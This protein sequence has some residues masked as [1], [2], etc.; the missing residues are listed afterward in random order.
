MTSSNRL[1]FGLVAAIS[2]LTVLIGTYAW[3]HLDC[4]PIG[5]ADCVPLQWDQAL[6]ASVLAIGGSDIYHNHP[7]AG[8]QF[9]RWLGAASGLA[10]VL[11]VVFVFAA[12][13]LRRRRVARLSGH[14]VLVGVND[15]S[16]SYLLARKARGDTLVLIDTE[17]VLSAQTLKDRSGD[18]LKAEIDFIDDAALDAA[19]GRSPAEVVFG[20]PEA[21]VN[22]E[23][24]Q[25]LVRLR[26]KFPMRIRSEKQNINADLDLWSHTF[27]AVPILSET[28]FT[29]RALVTELEPM[30]IA[31]LRGQDCPHIAIIGIGDMALGIIEELGLRCHARDL[32]KLK[33][34]T[35]DCDAEAAW[36]KLKMERGGL[37]DA[38]D[39][40]R[41]EQLD[42]AQCGS[43]GVAKDPLIAAEARVA[44]LTAIIVC[45]GSDAINVDI[46][47]RLRRLQDEQGLCLAPILMRSRATSTVAPDP[48]TDV[49]CGLYRFGGPQVRVTDL[50]FDKMQMRLGRAMH[51]IWNTAE[52]EYSVTW[53]SLTLGK[54]RTNTRAAL[55]AVEMFQ[56]LGLVPP[57]GA[58]AAELRLHPNVI[59]E[60]LDL[61]AAIA[62]LSVTE[63]DRWVA[64]RQAEGWTQT[65]A[66]PPTRKDRDDRRKIHWLM[67][68]FAQLQEHAA[69]EISKDS[70]NVRAVFKE[71]RRQYHADPSGSCWKKRV[72][73]GVMGP[74]SVG[75]DF[76]FT[77]TLSDFGD[78]LAERKIRTD[79]HRLEVVTPNAPGFD[80]VAAQALIADWNARGG[81]SDLLMLEAETEAFLDLYA[82]DH[83]TQDTSR[84]QSTALADAVT[85]RSR[86]MR[87]RGGP[88]PQAEFMAEVERGT[89]VMSDLC[90]LMIYMVGPEGGEMTKKAADTRAQRGGS[91]LMFRRP[92]VSNSGP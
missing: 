44:P 86:R 54:K 4:T 6:Y 35:F 18:I 21:S 81:V 89:H 74:L 45:T 77:A 2:V 67:L 37:L 46:A 12:G 88:I 51:E 14:L 55:S 72:R 43:L 68:P 79:T 60:V 24:A 61:K 28:E 38:V 69:Q 80:R 66:D 78:W 91:F 92:M 5:D 10:F 90:D 56:T 29:A 1:V 83:A 52:P 85:G 75:P 84:R 25:S 34:W 42:G 57:Q 50:A 22:V 70:N 33:I 31:R 11:G 47:L 58:A 15:F 26:G 63:H 82:L 19:L 13:W 7:D 8:V 53:D 9:T 16:L 32:G 36:T 48:I 87:L 71:A 23:R 39:M 41:T 20:D 62:D 30:N 73:V 40:P 76:D 27:D 17:V 49:T 59:D 3:M 64:E 65:T